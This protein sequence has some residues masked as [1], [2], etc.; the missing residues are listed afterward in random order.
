MAADQELILNILTFQHPEKTVTLGFHKEKHRGMAALSQREY[1]KSWEGKDPHPA[2]DAEYLYTDFDNPDGAELK[3]EIDLNESVNLAKRYYQK[4]V[5]DL[6]KGVA[7]VR[8]YNF[9]GD[10][11]LWFRTPSRDDHGLHAY[12]KFA[13]RPSCR[14]YTDRMELMVMYDGLSFLWPCSVQDYEEDTTDF[15]WVVHKGLCFR[16][17]DIPRES[18]IDF[19]HLY[20]VVNPKIK[21]Y[22]GIP[23]TYRKPDNKVKRY[24]EHISWFKQQFAD[25]GVLRNAFPAL[26]TDWL[27]PDIDNVSRVQDKCELL[28]FGGDQTERIPYYG[29]KKY[30]PFRPPAHP[31]YQI[32]FI[33]HENHTKSVGNELF[34]Y[35]DG[36][37]NNEYP[38]LA[39]FANIPVKL[40][41]KHITFCDLNNPLL[42]IRSQLRQIHFDPEVRYLGIYISP[43]REDE[44]DPVKHKVYYRI[45]EELLHYG[46]T[47][48]V[49]YRKNV[50]DPN[51]KYHLPNL[52][53]AILA[54]LGGI[55]WQL[56]KPPGNELLVGIGAFRTQKRKKPYVGSAFCFAHDGTFRGFQ[57]FSGND[58]TMLAGSIR[59]AVQHYKH[60]HKHA[61]RLIIHFYKTMSYRERKPILEA[62]DEL[63]LDIPVVVVT[64]NKT[65]SR[66][67]VVFDRFHDTMLP[68][69]GTYIH[70]GGGSWFL[71]NNT[72]YSGSSDKL[73]SFPFPVK[74]K[75]WASDE[76]ITGNKEEVRKLIEQIYQFSRLYWKSVSQQSLPV[77]IKYPEMIARLFPHFEGNTLPKTGQ[78]TLWFL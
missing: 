71:C 68:I 29:L 59:E 44:P 58:T 62:L 7:D 32:F 37:Q 27:T 36:R 11:R 51:F 69:S 8:V 63:N 70:A 1:P 21:K 22:L 48:Q 64:I 28:T 2:G 25:G 60:H 65:Q 39:R 5:F 23:F 40:S 3:A 73:R 26:S 75:L 50:S 45:K 46:I 15:G 41:Q 16:Y 77:T 49:I 24:Y 13:L 72:R 78:K 10:T 47:S 20:P 57:C 30:K 74:I 52:S 56:K 9:I 38:G 12:R 53:V 17:K 43:I 55:P 76:S 67:L 35:L 14:Q 66:E 34:K 42:E 19:E 6:F 54:K 18:G 4:R 33:L 31:H 61:K